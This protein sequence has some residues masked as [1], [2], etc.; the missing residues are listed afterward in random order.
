[1]K[2]V[3]V[4]Q[5]MLEIP[6]MFSEVIEHSRFRHWD[7]VSA[8]FCSFSGTE[9]V[10]INECFYVPRVT[11]WGNSASLEIQSRDEDAVLIERA[12]GK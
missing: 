2:Y 10:L 11:V 3:V 1:M 4:K 7:V 9:T 8:G 6:I 12:Q 5:G